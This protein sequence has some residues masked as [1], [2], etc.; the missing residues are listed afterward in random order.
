[1]R[2]SGTHSPSAGGNAR[3]SSVTYLPSAAPAEPARGCP[4]QAGP[5]SLP[6]QREADHDRDLDVG[7]GHVRRKRRQAGAAHHG[8]DRRVEIRISVSYPFGITP[9]TLA[10]RRAYACVGC[11]G[12]ALNGLIST[13]SGA[14]GN[15]GFGGNCSLLRMPGGRLMC[16]ETGPSLGGA[17]T[18]GFDRGSR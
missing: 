10:R 14:V 6:G 16:A 12:G 7:C 5:H 3:P 13:I 2:P 11:R 15:V 8:V 9:F 17:C 18:A 1:M 4:H